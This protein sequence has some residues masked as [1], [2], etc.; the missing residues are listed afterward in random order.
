M[1]VL[2]QELYLKF[3]FCVNPNFRSASGLQ[4]DPEPPSSSPQGHEVEHLRQ[5]VGHDGEVRK[6]PGGS[7]R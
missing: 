4:V 3:S 5:H 7:R 2:Q 1:S 6:Q